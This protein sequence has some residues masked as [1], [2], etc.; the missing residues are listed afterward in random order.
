MGDLGPEGPQIQDAAVYKAPVNTQGSGPN[1][2]LNEAPKQNFIKRLLKRAAPLVLIGGLSVGTGVVVDKVADGNVSNAIT[3]TATTV[4]QV[5]AGGEKQ[6]PL[7]GH[8][9]GP[10]GT[11]Y[12]LEVVPI[13]YP[14]HT[15]KELP[16]FYKSP[17]VSEDTE[18]KPEEFAGYGI[19]L[20]QDHVFGLRGR[21]VLGTPFTGVG[22]SISVKT[23]GIEE[24]YGGYARVDA[25]VDGRNTSF[26]V[27]ESNV[28]YVSSA[29]NVAQ[30]QQ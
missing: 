21:R 10:V 12:E 28:H 24:S 16:K 13:E 1:R 4:A 30:P 11:V 25:T 26:F 20:N 8:D 15:T 7:I 27:P 2:A 6:L 18:I 19:K 3:D 23:A 17:K 9:Q 5:A 22:G 29:P 14:G